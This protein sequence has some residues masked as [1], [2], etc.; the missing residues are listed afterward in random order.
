MKSIIFLAACVSALG[1]GNAAYA[2]SYTVYDATGGIGSGGD[3]VATTG[4]AGP[5]LAD[6]FVTSG[7]LA[8]QSVV[9]NLKLGS[10][11]AAGFTVDLFSDTGAGGPG[12]ATQIAFVQDTSLT[13]F[14][15]LE[16]YMPVTP[17]ILAAD[18]SYYIGI[19]DN[20]G[21]SAILG[22]TVDESVLGRSS[23]VAGADYYNSG[24]VQANAGGPYEIK[25]V[26]SSVPE[27][28][29]WISM[30]AGLGAVGI[31]RRTQQRSKTKSCPV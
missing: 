25:V 14:F 20:G 16:T 21:S 31:A 28:A 3:P 12:V 18:T 29:T 6:R 4:P 23:V 24:G 5:I 11:P 2:T 26:G 7:A 15:Q 9:L 1:A 27:P 10:M 17:I 13:T 19:L 8:L 30:L 22:N